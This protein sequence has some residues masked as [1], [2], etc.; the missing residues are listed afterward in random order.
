MLGEMWKPT[1]EEEKTSLIVK[2][3]D[4]TTTRPVGV[5]KDLKVKT[6]GL[7]YHVWF[8][9]MDFKNPIDSYDI[10]LGRPFLR[11]VGVVH[12]W[13]SNTLYLRKDASV[14]KVDL[15]MWKSRPLGG[16]LFAAE[17][18]TT[19]RTTTVNQFEAENEKIM[20]GDADE[21]WYAS[22]PE[23]EYSHNWMHLLATIDTP[24]KRGTH[25]VKDE[26]GS[27]GTI[28]PLR[29]I[30][31]VKQAHQETNKREMKEK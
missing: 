15:T 24:E 9:V 19:A 10:I 1:H 17:S 7:T 13:S 12:D 14:T 31:L 11:A 5:V 25:M 27:E 3:A 22:L 4:G 21:T 6:L 29:M 30:K 23:P 26:S 8:V 18:E 20:G 28:V 2:L 16:N